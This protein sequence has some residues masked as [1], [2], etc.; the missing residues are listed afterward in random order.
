MSSRQQVAT[1]VNKVRTADASG[2]VSI[3]PV[4]QINHEIIYS[5]ASLVLNLLGVVALSMIAI[6]VMRIDMYQREVA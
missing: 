4:R 5:Y 6:G 3:I 1:V 2:P